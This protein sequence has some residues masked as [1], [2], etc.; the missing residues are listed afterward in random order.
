VF[1]LTSLIA[2]G[3]A[4]PHASWAYQPREVALGYTATTMLLAVSLLTIFR[5]RGLTS[6]AALVPGRYLLPLDAVEVHAEDAAG[7]QLVVIT[8]LGDA[9]D[10]RVRECASGRELLIVLDGG[11]EVR[12][13]LRSEREGEHA[14]RRLEQSQALL[15]ELTYEGARERALATD[16]FF[17]VRATASWPSVAPSAPPGGRVVR[18]RRAS[19]HG[20]LATVGALVFGAGVG[21]AAFVGRAW[22]CDRALY[23]RAA[24]LGTTDAVDDY[25][26]RATSH[27]VDAE[28]LRER[29]LATARARCASP[30][31][32]TG[33]SSRR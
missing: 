11:A 7:R 16:P 8:P 19:M 25:L 30:S 31:R 22:A 1:A 17:E 9:R 12:F 21:W 20:S 29:T 27:R 28:A 33:C 6:G 23:L 32:G 18:R 10:A 2:V 4:D 13:G 24:R 3:F 15:E 26:L 5:R 14:E